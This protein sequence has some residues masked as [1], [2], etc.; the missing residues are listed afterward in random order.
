MAKGQ[1]R[2]WPRG[3]GCAA[4]ASVLTARSPLPASPSVTVP[5]RRFSAAR[6]EAG[7]PGPA[8]GAGAVAPERQILPAQ[9][10]RH[11]RV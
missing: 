9:R 1:K 8:E 7:T 5:F 4:L 6:P 2:R 3:I 10:P 11:L